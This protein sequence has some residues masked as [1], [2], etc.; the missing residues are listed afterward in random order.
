MQMT[1]EMI[2]HCGA[3]S[4]KAE[5]PVPYL[6][7]ML[8]SLHEQG[9]RTP[10]QMEASRAAYQ[11]QQEKGKEVAKPGGKV[12]REQQYEQREYEVTQGMT[13]RMAKRLKELKSN[14]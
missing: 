4:G 2:L 1:D 5:N 6:D 3:L 7:K 9:I 13:E 8:T 14:A 10:A 12:V 11:A